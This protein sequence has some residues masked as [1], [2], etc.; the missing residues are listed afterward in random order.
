MFNNIVT[1]EAR[2]TILRNFNTLAEGH[3]LKEPYSRHLNEASERRKK[4]NILFEERSDEF[5]FFP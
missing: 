4:K 3:F 5:I 2:I 1:E